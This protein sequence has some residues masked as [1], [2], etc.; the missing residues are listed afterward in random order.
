MAKK[1]KKRRRRRRKRLRKDT[2]AAGSGAIGSRPC[3]SRY[4]GLTTS[5]QRLSLAGL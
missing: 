1:K 3:S 2:R 5:Q 4:G